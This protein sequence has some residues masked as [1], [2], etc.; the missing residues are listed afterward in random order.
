MWS[1]SWGISF[2]PKY[3]ID[4][5]TAQNQCDHDVAL[6]VQTK[7][8]LTSDDCHIM[9]IGTLACF[10]ILVHVSQT[11]RFNSMGGSCNL[12]ATCAHLHALKQLGDDQ[13]SVHIQADPGVFPPWS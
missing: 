5:A 4:M 3:E 2:A 12:Q 13:E 1:F 9:F 7:L 8:I 6:H 11:Q 10:H